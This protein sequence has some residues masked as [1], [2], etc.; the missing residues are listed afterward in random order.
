VIADETELE[1]EFSQANGSTALRY[2][3]HAR[4]FTAWTRLRENPLLG[5]PAE[6]NDGVERHLHARPIIGDSNGG[7]PGRPSKRAPE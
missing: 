7:E 5:V 6:S 4:C 1:L 3:V 2:H